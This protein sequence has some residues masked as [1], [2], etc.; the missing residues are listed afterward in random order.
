M[1]WLGTLKI[2]EARPTLLELSGR[3]ATNIGLYARGIKGRANF[4][5]SIMMHGLSKAFDNTLIFDRE[6]CLCDQL[7]ERKS[8]E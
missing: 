2:D 8:E 7:S 6:L 3:H 5:L 4:L 1:L